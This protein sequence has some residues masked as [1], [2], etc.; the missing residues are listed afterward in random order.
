MTVNE[1][2]LSALSPLDCPVLADLYTGRERV[3]VTFHY[4]T[5]G[6]LFADDAPGCERCLIQVHFFCPYD[7]DYVGTA[8]EIKRLLFAGGFTWPEM[9]NATGDYAEAAK[10]GRHFVFE[11]ELAEGVGPCG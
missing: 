6:A 5:C 1:R 8:K 2:I 11:C 4:T 9:V 10:E 7:F 3:Y